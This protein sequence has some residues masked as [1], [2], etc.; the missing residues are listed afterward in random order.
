MGH[1]PRAL[2]RKKTLNR[3]Q[4]SNKIGKV[5]DQKLKW[6]QN[7]KNKIISKNKEKH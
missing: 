1:L 2:A 3:D 6:F 5:Q 4:E 7:E